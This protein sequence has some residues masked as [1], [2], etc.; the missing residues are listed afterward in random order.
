MPL[1]AC[2]SSASDVARTL[3][4]TNASPTSSPYDFQFDSLALQLRE[5]EAQKVLQT[6][7]KLKEIRLVCFFFP[8][9]DPKIPGR[10]LSK[11]WMARLDAINSLLG[12][13]QSKGT[14]WNNDGFKSYKAEE[15]ARRLKPE[16]P[17]STVW[18]CEWTMPSTDSMMD[19][20]QLAVDI[21]SY[22]S[23]AFR[24]VPFTELA[25]AACG[26]TSDT[27]TSLLD[28]I[29]N[30][31]NE[32]SRLVQECPHLR[33]KYKLIEKASPTRTLEEASGINIFDRNYA[34]SIRWHTGSSLQA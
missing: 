3:Q 14:P 27:L 20:K 4:S 22:I 5:E 10:V 34:P 13:E 29:S 32:L 19:A 12:L 18:G 25:R 9:S 11:R 24:K 23:T 1:P 21:N 16:L 26:R 30:I 8:F 6:S 31:R 15:I 33:N 7:V 28:G 2:S 17:P